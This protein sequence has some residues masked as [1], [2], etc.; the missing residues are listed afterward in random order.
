VVESRAASGTPCAE[1]SPVILRSSE[2]ESEQ[3]HTV[4][5][6]VGFIGTGAAWARVWLGAAWCARG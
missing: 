2:V 4:E 6:L 3:G 5:A 1:R